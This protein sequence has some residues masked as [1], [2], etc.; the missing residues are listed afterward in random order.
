[1]NMIMHGDGHGGV[2]QHE[3]LSDVN[4]IEEGIFDVILTNPP[5]GSRVADD[6]KDA[7]DPKKNLVDKYA[8]AKLSKLKEVLF[9]ERCL[10]LL[11]AGGRM[12]IVLPEGFLNNSQL[13]NVREYFE[14]KAKIL[15]I[16]SIPQ[17]VFVA[18][19]ATVKSSLIFLRKFTDAEARLY[20][21]IT[22]EAT[23]EINIKYEPDEAEAVKPVEDLE[24][25][26]KDEK[27]KKKKDELR[28]QLAA[29]KTEMKKRLAEIETKKRAEIRA[30]VKER[31]DYQV[32]VAQV[33]KAG[34]TATGGA[35]ENELDGVAAEF[36][37]YRTRENLWESKTL[38]ISY[39]YDAGKL[40]RVTDGKEELMSGV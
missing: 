38:D 2:H 21:L 39:K 34:I 22:E 32:P 24:Q 36:Y 19:G 37:D 18:A 7:K 12:G 30:I 35:C 5:F 31:F 1:M 20:E 15:L 9:T 11:K 4:G 13:Q 8:V 27:E 26:L 25:Q 33:E 23:D 3:G 17:D 16:T 6:L 10:N 14:G 29:A 40:Y 28:P